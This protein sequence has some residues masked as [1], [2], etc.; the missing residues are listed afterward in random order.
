MVEYLH[1]KKKKIT[2]KTCCHVCFKVLSFM[3]QRKLEPN[4]DWSRFGVSLPDTG[5]PDLFTWESS[6]GDFNLKF[7]VIWNTTF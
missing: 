7:P 5:I 3:G 2:K 1:S 6:K 4:A